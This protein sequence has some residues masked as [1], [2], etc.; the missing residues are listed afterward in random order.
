M[1]LIAFMVYRYM[2]L[3][4]SRPS[5]YTQKYAKARE[6]N[7]VRIRIYTD[8]ACSENPGPGGW[9]FVVNTD[10]TCNTFSGGASSTTNNRM[11]LTG[12][13]E[14]LRYI[15]SHAD[16]GNVYE[17]YC[18]SAYVVNSINNKWLEGWKL[19]G[20]K[21]KQG[22]DIKNRD[23]WEALSVQMY[24]C[25]KMGQQIT[26]VKVKGHDGNTF[27]ELVDKLARSE[28]MKAKAGVHT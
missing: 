17:I 10:S 3:W 19:N 21:T 15:A 23:L 18:D 11:E 28:S 2:K 8:G 1:Y 12:V 22:D 5:G 14:A 16:S 24:I 6:C 20:W 9:A 25:R 26:F 13:V 4:P 27:N 7:V